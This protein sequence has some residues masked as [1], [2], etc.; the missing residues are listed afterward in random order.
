MNGTATAVGA[1]ATT[2]A[3]SPRSV[4]IHWTATT[5]T[6]TAVAFTSWTPSSNRKTRTRRAERGLSEA[7]CMPVLL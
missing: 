2:V 3:D 7:L 1:S 4:R 6:H 5:W